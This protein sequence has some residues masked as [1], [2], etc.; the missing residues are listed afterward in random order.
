M[1]EFAHYRRFVERHHPDQG[2]ASWSNLATALDA[3]RAS[4]F[5]DQ[6]LSSQDLRAAVA[7]PVRDPGGEAIASLAIS[8][9]IEST[10]SGGT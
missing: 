1:G 7:L 9:P 2:T 5:A 10:G 3:A 4:G 6:P 8:G